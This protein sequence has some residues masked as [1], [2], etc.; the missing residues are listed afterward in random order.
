MRRVLAIVVAPILLGGCVEKPLDMAPVKP[1]ARKPIPTTR[2]ATQPLKAP[3]KIEP[4]FPPPEFTDHV[5]P[6]TDQPAQ[7]AILYEYIDVAVLAAALAVAS[8]LA[9]RRQ[10]R[11]G[12]VALT[13]FSLAYFGF[14]R[15]GCICPVGAIQN[16]TLAVFDGGYSI[17]I[18][19]AAIFVLPLGFTLFFGRSFC[20]GVCPLGAV[21][22]LVLIHPVRVPQWLAGSLRVVAYVYLGGAVTLAACGAGFIICRYDPFV[23]IF[24]LGGRL[25]MVVLGVCFLAAGL[26]VGRP[27]CRFFCPYGVLLGWVSKVSK[28]RV[29]ITPDKCIQCGLCEESCPFGA[30]RRPNADEAPSR[31]QGKGVLASMIAVLPV[32]AGAGA[33]GGYLFGPVM[34]RAHAT[35]QLSARIE[36][37]DSGLV[38]G[39][40]DESD[41]FRITARTGKELHKEAAA[42]KNDFLTGG[43]LFGGFIG[44]VIGCMLVRLS[45]RRTRTDYVADRT[46]C[47]AC[48]RCFQYCPVHRKPQAKLKQQAEAQ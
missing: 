21:Q 33:G 2:P 44:L 40:T 48:G 25:E 32:L 9:L 12:M 37:E 1:P 28:W 14:Y 19:V 3:P 17:P 39:T 7:R 35:V 46:T 43:A 24:R 27:Y 31:L 4:R 26:F 13:I 47:L 30:I 41:A 8:W 11:N 34:S 15:E 22:D 29:S 45:V 18:F 23:P 38:T 5:L 36:Q 16:V 42:I 20:A 6:Q 10:S